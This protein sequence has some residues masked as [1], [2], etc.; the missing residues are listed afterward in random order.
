MKKTLFPTGKNK[1]NG[2]MLTLSLRRKVFIKFSAIIAY[3]AGIILHHE[4]F[5]L[6][7]VFLISTKER[8]V[9]GKFKKVDEI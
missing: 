5:F 1:Q 7:T 3:F 8:L 9:D 2:S 4:D 6:S